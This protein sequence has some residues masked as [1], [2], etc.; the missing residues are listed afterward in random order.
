MQK[1][2]SDFHFPFPFPSYRLPPSPFDLP[3]HLNPQNSN[4]TETRTSRSS[5][6][7]I[8]NPS[9]TPLSEEHFERL[10]EKITSQLEAQ[11]L[12]SAE[13]V[14]RTVQIHSS[15]IRGSIAAKIEIECGALKRDLQDEIKR[16]FQINRHIANEELQAYEKKTARILERIDVLE[17]NQRR[18]LCEISYN[19]SKIEEKQN[20]Q[21]KKLEQ[22]IDHLQA[23]LTSLWNEIQKGTF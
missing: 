19:L 4:Q 21:I 9:H 22:K 18:K 1:I 23:E 16:L 10:K 3:S 11:I 8:L 6:R 7:T 5:P 2:D 12:K 14:Q 15:E 17:Q 20:E 13:S